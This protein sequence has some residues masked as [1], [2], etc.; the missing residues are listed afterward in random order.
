LVLE[1]L[2]VKIAGTTILLSSITEVAMD[3]LTQPL[4]ANISIM[5]TEHPLLDR[6]AAA[7]RAGF[8]QVEMW[9]PYGEPVAPAAEVE[10]LL[11]ALAQA[12]VRLTGLNFFA[13]DMPNGERGVASHPDRQEDLRG[14]TRQL[15]AIAAATGC[16][17]FNLLYGQRDER[18]TPAE[19]DRTA[20]EAVAAA[21][22]AVRGIGGTVLL[23]PLAEG[24]NGAYPLLDPIQIINM[25]TGPLAGHDNVRLLFD[26]FHIGSNGFDIVARARECAPWIGH[27]QIADSPGRGEPGSGSLPIREC[28]AALREVGY[29]GTAACE[30]KPTGPTESTLAWIG[31]RG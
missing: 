17:A 16:R 28:L 9:W 1:N 12:Q 26:L 27:V 6:P 2:S 18:W 24:L 30:Y 5:F 19:Q 7:R 29:E 21:A 31:H 22:Q 15:L 20:V 11:D 8:A 23:E 25:I 13:G 3:A 4:A 10:A 14:N